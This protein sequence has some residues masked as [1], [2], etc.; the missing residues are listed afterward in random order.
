MYPPITLFTNQVDTA[1]LKTCNTCGPEIWYWILGQQVD[2]WYRHYWMKKWLINVWWMCE[3]SEKRETILIEF[4]WLFQVEC[5]WMWFHWSSWKQ[6]ASKQTP[7]PAR[8]P[9]RLVKWMRIEWMKFM[10]ITVLWSDLPLN[11]QIC[12]LL[13]FDFSFVRLRTR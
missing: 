12:E 3:K 9:G 8:Y 10:I 11:S 6:S 5:K 13:D 7:T 2:F 4:K 1:S